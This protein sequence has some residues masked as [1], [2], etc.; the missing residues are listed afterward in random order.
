MSVVA[1]D[2]IVYGSA[3][4]PDADGATTGGAVAFSKRVAFN[5]ISPTGTMS[6][7]S[8]STSDTVTVT[9]TGRLASGVTTTEAKTTTGQSIVAGAVAFER[10]LK[11]IVSGGTASGDIAA[12]SSAAVVSG[13]SQGGAA[14]VTGGSGILGL[15][16]RIRIAAGQGA[17]V[18]TGQVLMVTNNNPPG[19]QNCLRY[20]VGTGTNIDPNASADDLYLNRDWPVIPNTSTTYTVNEGM[21][22]EVLPNQ[23]TEIRRPF[24]NAVAQASGGSTTTYYEKV[25]YVNN[26]TSIA[27][28]GVSIQ[29]FSDFPALPGLATIEFALNDGLNDTATTANRQTLPTN[30]DATSLVFTAGNPPQSQ[31]VPGAGNLPN[32]AVPNSAGAMGIWLKLTLPAG[33]SAYKGYFTLK[34]NGSTV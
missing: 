22:W 24:Y 10:L 17:S 28:T 31:S 7:V 23:V 21:L 19:I 14:A 16:A 18:S 12:I 6:Y 15:P 9:L 5:D 11:G 2:L 27:L 8:S 13:T 3:N 32:G 4:M 29:H 30:G 33:T 1:S 25:F 26:N 34:A 20:I